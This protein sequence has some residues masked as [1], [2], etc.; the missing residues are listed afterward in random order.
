MTLDGGLP[1][2]Y[3]YRDD[4]ELAEHVPLLVETTEPPSQGASTAAT[5]YP[6]T[7]DLPTLDQVH[8]TGL[9]KCNCF[10][11]QRSDFPRN[12]GWAFRNAVVAALATFLA[13]KFPDI[14]GFPHAVLLPML[15]VS[16]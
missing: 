2:L 9:K 10:G 3:Y 13:M 4:I 14:F 1:T 7:L 8:L 6:E 12:I 16:E 15:A 5:E 11:F